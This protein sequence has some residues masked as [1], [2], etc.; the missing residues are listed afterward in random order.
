MI[1]MGILMRTRAYNLC[2]L[3]W[4]IMVKMTEMGE[5][6]ENGLVVLVEDY[7]RWKEKAVMAVYRLIG[8]LIVS[9]E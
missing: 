1:V 9:G 2:K 3:L 7:I 8:R 4:H 6:V 5:R